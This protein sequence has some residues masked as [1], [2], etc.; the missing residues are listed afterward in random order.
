[1][2]TF[3]EELREH[4][5]W[6]IQ[7]QRLRA[8]ICWHVSGDRNLKEYF[9]ALCPKPTSKTN[10]TGLQDSQGTL[11][12]NQVGMEQVGMDFY[13]A[14]YSRQQDSLATVEAQGWVLTGFHSRLSP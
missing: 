2:A 3:L 10:I 5:K 6:D 9:Q 13:A 7:D 4:E 1:M 14:L 12:T 11:R 8:S